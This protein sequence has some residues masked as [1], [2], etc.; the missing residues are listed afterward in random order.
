M[1]SYLIT[2][3]KGKYSLQAEIDK[4]TG[5]FCRDEQG[6]LENYTDVWIDCKGGRVFHFGGRVLE[7]YS[8]RLMSGKNVVK[9]INDENPSLIYDVLITDGEV[10]FKFKAKDIEQLEKFI[11][12]KTQS[13]DRGCFSV[14]NIRKQ[15]AKN[16]VEKYAIPLLELEEYKAISAQ[17]SK[18]D[19]SIYNRINKGFIDALAKKMRTN[20]DDL[21][22]KIKISGMKT[23]EYIHSLGNETWVNYLDYMQNYIKGE[24]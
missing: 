24:I 14:K 2:N 6:N 19:I 11:K 21:K 1:S 3:Y 16:G 7:Y 20:S 9:A 4:R 12:P 15:Q 17:I 10:V 13:A 8:N 22:Y 18:D 23:K 5:D